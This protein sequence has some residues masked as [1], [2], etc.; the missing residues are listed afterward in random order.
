MCLTEPPLPRDLRLVCAGIRVRSRGGGWGW[1]RGRPV[2][3]ALRWPLP[4]ASEVRGK[5]ER[6]PARG[7][8]SAAPQE[9]RGHQTTK[10]GRRGPSGCPEDAL[11]RDEDAAPGLANG[12]V[13]N[14]GFYIKKKK[15]EKN[16]LP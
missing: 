5:P 16:A 9:G 15:S 2:A 3:S 14:V 12:S 6:H 13:N 4:S 1:V 10:P 11:S 7:A 8:Q